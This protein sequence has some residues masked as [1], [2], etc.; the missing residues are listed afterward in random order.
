LSNV[1]KLKFS[2]YSINTTMKAEAAK[3]PAS[4]VNSLVELYVAYFNRTPDAS[5]LAYWIDKASAGETLTAIS[6]EFYAAGVQY[7]SVTGYSSTM[8]N[9][10]F[11]K[12]VYTNVLGRSGT[13]APPAADI[14]YWDNQINTGATTKDGLMQTMLAA[15]HTFANDPTWGWVPK[16]LDNKIAVGYQSAVT[17]GLDYNSPQDAITQGMAVAHAV[18]ATDT[19]VAIGLIG[20]ATHIVL[21]S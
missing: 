1:E 16:L 10:D 3:L 12:L 6:K 4:T 15:A 5:G 11:I 18:T 20:M 2:D 7:S 8:A 14:A 13:T 9:A 19:S 21:A 17:Y